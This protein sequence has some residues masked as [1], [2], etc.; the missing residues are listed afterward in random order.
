[1]PLI[2]KRAYQ[3]KIARG[4]EIATYVRAIFYLFISV[5]LVRKF[6]FIVA[7]IK[8][9]TKVDNIK[10][11]ENDKIQDIKQE[12]LADAKVSAR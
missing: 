5:I 7:Y 4:L 9:K 2:A 10:Y 1:M 12:S 6:L 8:V 11:C 3:L